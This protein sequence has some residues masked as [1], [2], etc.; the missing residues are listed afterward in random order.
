MGGV[1]F[2]LLDGHSKRTFSQPQRKRRG[3]SHKQAT[4]A[5]TPTSNTSHLYFLFWDLFPRSVGGEEEEVVVLFVP[6]GRKGV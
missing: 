4:H 3:R 2:G 6:K 1:W 5:E